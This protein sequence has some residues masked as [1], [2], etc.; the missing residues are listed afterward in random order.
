MA[1]LMQRYPVLVNI[2]FGRIDHIKDTPFGTLV[3]ELSG[4]SGALNE[5]TEYLARQDLQVEVLRDV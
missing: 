4:K 1:D 5:A 3:V 2:L